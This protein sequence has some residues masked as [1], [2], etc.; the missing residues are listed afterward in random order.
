MIAQIYGIGSYE[1]AIGSYEA[2]ADNI[3]IL[4]PPAYEAAYPGILPE[5]TVLRIMQDLKGKCTVILLSESDDPAEY[6]R[7]AEV[8]HP[9]IIQIAG[10]T[11]AADADFRE[12]LRMIDPAVKI[13]QSV[14]VGSDVDAAVQM[15]VERAPFADF[16]ITDSL[17]PGGEVGASGITHSREAD[18]EIVRV[19][20]IPVVLAGGLG[21]DNAAEVAAYASPYGLDS[22]TKTNIPGT[23]RKDLKLVKEFCDICHRF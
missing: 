10:R 1:D 3:G 7:I 13:M 21:C 15:A 9:E 11:F 12:K 2:G 4:P 22:L 19:A 17:R 20:G 6:L 16:L 23:F 18:R 14:P 8:Y 5:E